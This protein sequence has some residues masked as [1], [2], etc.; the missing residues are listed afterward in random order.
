[1]E[2]VYPAPPPP[3]P[4]VA[5][6]RTHRWGLWSFV[7]V[8]A[9]FLLVSYGLAIAGGGPLPAST[10]AAAIAI[11]TMTAAAVAVLITVVRGNGP[12]IDLELTWSWRQVGIGALFGFGGLF[13]TIPASFVY[14]TLTDTNSAVG[15]VFT[16]V[17][18]AWQWALLVFLLLVFVV[19]L[20]EEI[21][22]RGLLWGGLERRWN[23]WVALVVSTIL[24]AVAHFGLTRAPLLLIVAIPIA[25]ARFYGGG[26]LASIIAHQANNLLPGFVVAMGLL[27]MMPPV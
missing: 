12:K 3:P 21:M 27:G 19:P 5:P 8:E 24:F 9:V 16:D 2:P 10:L 15:Q 11:P 23:R 4:P 20:C 17:R 6:Q 18:A 22:F 25:L 13:V 1:M 26:L 14:V 7:V